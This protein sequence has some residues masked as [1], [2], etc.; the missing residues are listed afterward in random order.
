MTKEYDP[1]EMGLV[2]M[3][4]A[5]DILRHVVPDRALWN[6][7]CTGDYEIKPGRIEQ[8]PAVVAIWEKEG[9]VFYVKQS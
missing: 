5:M 6:A 3:L 1:I 2:D 7:C 9:L 8:I 4:R